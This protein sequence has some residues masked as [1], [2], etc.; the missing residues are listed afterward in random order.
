MLGS[1]WWSV[2]R[3]RLS[4]LLLRPRV[5]R[6][7]ERELRFHLE[8]ETAEN[9][10]LGMNASE[11]R[12]A[13]RRS[14]G[15][16]ALV[17]DECRDM[18][19]TEYVQDLWN[20]LRYAARMLKKSPRFAVV[21]VLTLA[22]SIGANSA[23]FSVIDGVLLRP[24]PYG[25]AER[26]VRVFLSN[27]QYPKFPLNPNDFRDYRERNHS[28][29]RMAAFSRG[30]L[31]L[32]GNGTAVK[33]TGFRVT[34]GFF[35]TLGLKPARGR[36]FEWKDELPGNERQVILSDRAWR[37]EF[38]G[39]EDIVGRKITLNSQPFTVAGVMPPGVEHPGNSYNPIPNGE[40]VD[41]WWP[42][43][44]EGDVKQRGSHYIEGI[45][46]M[47]PGVS[48][49]AAQ[50]ELNSIMAELARTYEGDRNWNVLVNPLYREI[51]GPVR[52]ML[53]LLLG[54]VGL[55]LL[56]ACV[57]A[58]NLLLARATS[59]RR[60]MAVRAA[61]GA[62]RGRLFRQM[63]AEGLVIAALGGG[64]GVLM[65]VG[66]VK[67]LVA[68]LPAGFPR[69]A[70]IHLNETVFA[71]T[72][73]ITLATG[74]LF[75]LV[76]ALQAARTD[77]QEGLREG[78][79]GWSGSRR[80]VRLR[81]LLVVG[82]VGLACVLLIGAGLLLRSFTNLLRTDPGFRM[83]QVVT[84]SITLPRETYRDKKAVIQFYE[85]LLPV[86]R[87]SPEISAAGVG[88]DLPWTGYDDNVGGFTIE[89]KKPAPGDQFH[90]RYH[91][92]SAGYFEAMGIPI[93]K[94][95]AFSE[96]DKVG[97]PF[98]LIINEAMERRYWPEGAIGR[99]ITFGDPPKEED[100]MTVVGVVGDVKDRPDRPAAEPALWWADTQMPWPFPDMKIVVRSRAEAAQLG[101]V[102]RQTVGE[103]DPTLAVSDVR[104]MD[105]IA[106]ESYSAAR[107]TLLLVALFAALA[108][109]LSSIG[110]YGVIAYS[111]EQR[112]H[113]F[114]MRMA[115]G[116]ARWQVL[117]M[118]LGQGTRLAL[119]GVV[120]G[121]AC[122]LGLAQLLSTLLY[123]VT[124]RD[125]MTFG[126]VALTALGIAVVACYPAA[127]RATGADPM[128]VLRAE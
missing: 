36:E 48:A 69:A 37:R 96:R 32:S 102:L 121:V 90:A 27:N 63:L 91:C 58:A 12:E 34:A 115:M 107:F 51:V 79:R 11:A 125:P 6:D 81:G 88:T 71:F 87:T 60:E 109:T 110:I 54:A 70:A 56:I 14:F 95:R 113:E 43:A 112:Q 106:D 24:L 50:S 84:A 77:P 127:R 21:I 45:A 40:T 2:A 20:D 105:V 15:G 26:L 128:V 64:L 35:A 62:G 74:L 59:R 66:G 38:G 19:R 108:L 86:L 3:M 67:V 33:L 46:R 8:Q 104:R 93:L 97:A 65:A 29:E 61:L 89:G 83:Q 100:W 92:A 122:A 116:A 41:V 53:L 85:R 119:V 114:G 49:A 25:D 94:G 22:L 118:V 101:N 44:F 23:I 17:E 103:F 99:R 42:F 28:F 5:E 52:A 31:Q 68:N 98:A 120:M 10:A 82:E 126:A 9:R 47:K 73:V 16:V 55:V 72:L 7:L 30:D 80:Q 75:G 4:S 124:A 13:A 78:G 117:R 57:N 1:R 111:V 18:R 123:G 39:A 76:P